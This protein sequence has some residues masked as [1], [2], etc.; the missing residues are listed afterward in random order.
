MFYRGRTVRSSRT[1]R[2]LLDE[3]GA[4]THHLLV[5]GHRVNDTQGGALTRV[6]ADA[7]LI[8]P[9]VV[10]VVLAVLLLMMRCEKVI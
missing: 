5:R 2:P 7:V 6:T 3:N 8:D 1:V 10:A 9:K 4:N